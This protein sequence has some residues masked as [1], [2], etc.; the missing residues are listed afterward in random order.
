VTGRATR[1]GVPF[2][3]AFEEPAQPTDPGDEVPDSPHLRLLKKRKAEALESAEHYERAIKAE[4]E[5]MAR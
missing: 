3:A 4:E 1:Y 5:R 2:A